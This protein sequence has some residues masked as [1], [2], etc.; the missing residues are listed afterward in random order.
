MKVGVIYKIEESIIGHYGADSRYNTDCN[1]R[2]THIVDF[3]ALG[4]KY[5]NDKDGKGLPK[6]KSYDFVQNE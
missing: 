5:Q 3:F 6:D 2:Y 4:V 1:K